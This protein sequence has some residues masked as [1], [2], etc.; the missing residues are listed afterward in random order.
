[1]EEFE[2]DPQDLLLEN[3]L[4]VVFRAGEL[5]DN[6]GVTASDL[7]DLSGALRDA[8]EII[9]SIESACGCG[10]EHEEEE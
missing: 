6:E 3:A 7:K 2:I 9:L 4:R 5:L 10:H 8:T 1:M